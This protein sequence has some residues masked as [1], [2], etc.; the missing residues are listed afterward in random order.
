MGAALAAAQVADEVG[1]TLSVIGTPAEEVGN[2][3][4]KILLLERWRLCGPSRRHDGAPG[5]L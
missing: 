3:S 1:L 4:G 5:A 2:A